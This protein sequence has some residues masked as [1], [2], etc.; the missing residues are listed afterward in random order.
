MEP[1]GYAYQLR[2]LRNLEKAR[3]K[4]YTDRALTVLARR[5]DTIDASD[6]PPSRKDAARQAAMRQ[7]DVFMERPLPANG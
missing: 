7:W 3:A 2:T 5:I 4:D 1:N 6:L